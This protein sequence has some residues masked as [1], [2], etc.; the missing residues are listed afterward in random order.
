M[1]E[2]ITKH[3]GIVLGLAISLYTIY[4]HV[5]KRVLRRR[6]QYAL[7]RNL[8]QEIAYFSDL[9]TNLARR[10]DQA[11]T[12]YKPKYVGRPLPYEPTEA[13]ALPPDAQVSTLWLVRRAKH[14]IDYKLRLDIEKLGEM[15]HRGQLEALFDLL[16]AR[17]VYIQVLA[18]RAMDLEAFPR[19]SDALIRFAAVAHL[20]IESVKGKLNAFAGSLGLP[21]ADF[22]VQATDAAAPPPD[23]APRR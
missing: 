18:T 8:H 2:E 9:A 4:T 3:S 15:L 5:E 11:M 14:L 20:N 6:R 16:T 7:L 1:W 23:A 22:E 17:R 21:G 19:S 12:R 10:A 13:D